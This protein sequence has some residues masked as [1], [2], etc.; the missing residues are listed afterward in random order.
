MSLFKSTKVIGLDIGTSFIKLAEIE[1]SRKG[2]TLVSFGI[3]PTPPGSITSRGEIIDP[4]SVATVIKDLV[5]QVKTKRKNV[6]VGMWGSAVMVKK[7]TGPRMSEQ[8]LQANLKFEAEQYIPFDINEINLDFSILKGKNN[9]AETMDYLLIAAQREF[10]FK[11]AEVVETAELQ[12][13]IIDVA[14]FSL[15]NCYQFNYGSGNPGEVVALL[16]VGAGVSNFVV[17]DNG[18]VVFSR[19][20]PVGGL[21]FTNEIHKQLGISV[22]EAESMKISASNGQNA[23]QEVSDIIKSTLETVIEEIHRGFDFF[24]ATANDSQIQRILVSGGSALIPGFTEQLAQVTSIPV[25]MFN[26][27]TTVSYNPKAMTPEYIRQITPYAAISIGLALRK[28]DD[29]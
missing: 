22:L 13:T 15:A 6:A 21:S 20:I 29:R 9:S 16:N 27:F 24:T 17:V 26:P 25:E 14:G 5:K 8:D 4:I 3:V 1:A 11:L 12:C 7:I 2:A 10:L 19:D 23:P 18:D 28:A